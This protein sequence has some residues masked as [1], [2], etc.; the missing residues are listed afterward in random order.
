[1]NSGIVNRLSKLVVRAG[2]V[3]EDDDPELRLKKTIIMAWSLMINVVAAIWG[4]TY[5]VS[6]AQ[7]ASLIP[8][9]Y[10]FLSL[11]YIYLYRSGRSWEF[12]RSAQ[13]SLILVHPTLLMLILGGFRDGS[14]VILWSLVAPLGALLVAERRQAV[15]W[16]LAYSGLLLLAT[17]LDPLFP[18]IDS[19]PSAIVTLFFFMNIATVSAIAFVLLYVFLGQK[20]A[21]IQQSKLL[22]A[23]AREARSAAETANQAKSV[24]LA[25]MS[26]EI[27]TPMNAVIGMTSLLRSTDLTREQQ[28]FAETIRRSSEDLLSIIN[29]ILDFSKMEAAKLELEDQPFDLRLC[30]ETALDLVS[31]MAAAKGLNLAYTV[32]DHTPESITGDVTRLRQILVN[33]LGNAVKFTEHGEVLLGVTSH[34]LDDSG[35]FNLRVLCERHRDRNPTRSH[36]ASFSVLQPG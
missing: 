14:A 1:M 25:N 33:L 21:A 8:F 12:F 10:L 27:R 9:S 6:G 7:I 32:C 29:D 26:H 11:L 18:E 13:I 24:F 31:P 23:E 28:E 17:I 2:R 16:M 22:Y 15:R 34:R 35:T 3:E 19:L 36:T 5:L 4:T 30:I 20:D